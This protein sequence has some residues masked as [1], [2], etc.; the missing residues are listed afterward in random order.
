VDAGYAELMRQRDALGRGA[1]VLD[2][3]KNAIRPAELA[4]EIQTGAQPQG[5]MV[6][7]SAAPARLRQGVRAELD[8]LVGT[9]ANDLGALERTIGTPQDWNS[10]KLA[11]LFG[12]DARNGV[13]DAVAANRKFRDTFQKVAQGSQTAQRS[14]AAAALD[15]SASIPRDITLT[16]I[17]ANIAGRIARSLVGAGN[18]SSKDQLAEV[19]ASSGPTAERIARL[20]L[21]TTARTKSNANAIRDLIASPGVVGGSAPAYGRQR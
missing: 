4:T 12:E 17:G 9:K 2:N 1:D 21:L 8:R 16:G 19:L 10:R 20:L 3:G 11:L 13:S 5:Q 6:G 18:G 7:P 14:E 15:S